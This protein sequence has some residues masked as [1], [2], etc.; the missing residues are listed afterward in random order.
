[1]VIQVED[2]RGE[3]LGLA[4]KVGRVVTTDSLETSTQEYRQ[5]WGTAR[6]G[7]KV[8]VTGVSE[9]AQQAG[10]ELTGQAL[11]LSQRD[12]PPG[13]LGCASPR[14]CCPGTS[15]GVYVEQHAGSGL[16]S[17]ASTFRFCDPH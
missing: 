4:S 14:C 10:R 3:W 6:Q 12:R 2:T 5:W 9:T 16:L 7:Y 1:M 13:E 17:S 15:C 11:V 8:G